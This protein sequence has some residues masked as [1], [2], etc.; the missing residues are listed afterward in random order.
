MMNFIVYNAYGHYAAMRI[1]YKLLRDYQS[2]R[3][4]AGYV[5][6]LRVQAVL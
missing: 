6:P 1:I 5:C 4:N 3:P 2:L